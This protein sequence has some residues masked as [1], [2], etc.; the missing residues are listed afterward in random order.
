M[1]S[2]WLEPA[3]LRLLRRGIL[4]D[5]FRSNILSI[6]WRA[7]PSSESAKSGLKSNHY[8][9]SCR[10][11][12]LLLNVPAS[13]SGRLE[14]TLLFLF[15]KPLFTSAVVSIK[16]ILKVLMGWKV[17]VDV[18]WTETIVFRSWDACCCE[19]RRSR[20]A[21]VTSLA[22]M[23][24]RRLGIID[25][26]L[27]ALTEFDIAFWKYCQTERRALRS[28]RKQ[29]FMNPGGQ[30]ISHKIVLR[31]SVSTV[32]TGLTICVYSSQLTVP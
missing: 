5:C 22:R 9:V 4:G 19:W 1:W 17:N 29:S 23:Q 27:N 14:E 18:Q 25:T 6:L 3:L 26:S 32:S 31:D 8:K 24:T 21:I 16:T 11:R 13:Y 28:R 15:W 30:L 2:D 20:P 12:S 10:V 7:L